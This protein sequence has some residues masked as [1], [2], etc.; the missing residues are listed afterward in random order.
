MSEQTINLSDGTTNWTF[1][2]HKIGQTYHAKAGIYAFA[3]MAS[4]GKWDIHYI[5]ETSDLNDRVGAGLN[6]HHRI[7]AAKRKGAT[8]IFARLF[9][10]TDDQRRALEAKLR[11]NYDPPC[12][13]Q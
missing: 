10:G 4:N 2:V 3:G 13:K 7:D 1:H 9:D 6:K 12:N 11:S 5:G 8:H